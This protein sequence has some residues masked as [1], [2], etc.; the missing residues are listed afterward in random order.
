MNLINCPKCG[1]Q[2]IYHYTDAFVIRTPVLKTDGKIGFI[3]DCI[4]EYDNCFFECTYC[5]YQP[6]EK[7]LLTHQLH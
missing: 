2:T 6:T 4:S 5:G 7:E 1:N 3:E